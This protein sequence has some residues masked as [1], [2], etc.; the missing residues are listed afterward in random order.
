M[1][2]ELLVADEGELE[3]RT[4]TKSPSGASPNLVSLV[5]RWG[6]CGTRHG[7]LAKCGDSCSLLRARSM[8]STNSMLNRLRKFR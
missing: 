8:H 1:Y 5:R 2:D 4:L 7:N 3:P 6:R